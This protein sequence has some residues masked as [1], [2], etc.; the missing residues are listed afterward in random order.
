MSLVYTDVDRLNAAKYAQPFLKLDWLKTLFKKQPYIFSWLDVSVEIKQPDNTMYIPPGLKFYDVTIKPSKIFCEKFSCMPTLFDRPC[1][2]FDETQILRIGDANDFMYACQPSCFDTVFQSKTDN[3]KTT[4]LTLDWDETTQ[5][6]NLLE[7]RSLAYMLA[8]YTRNLKRVTRL[9]DLPV[10]FTKVKDDSIGLATPYFFKTNKTYCD[11]FYIGYDGYECKDPDDIPHRLTDLFIGSEVIRT[12]KNYYRI[13]S[14]LVQDHTFKEYVD[15]PAFNPPEI[16]DYLTRIG[17]HMHINPHFTIPQIETS[18]SNIVKRDVTFTSF[19]TT[20]VSENIVSF[21]AKL[22]DGLLKSFS[23]LNSLQDMGI[24]LAGDSALGAIKSMLKKIT[25][26]LFK[27]MLTSL[28]KVSESTVLSKAVA[29]ALMVNSVRQV[30]EMSIVKVGIELIIEGA[31]S[32]VS[33][34]GF[35]TLVST[36]MDILLRYMDIFSFNSMINTPH[37]K[38]IWTTSQSS[39]FK[40][41]NG[42]VELDWNRIICF[43]FTHEQLL[44]F[45]TTPEHYLNSLKYLDA[46]TVNSDGRPIDRSEGINT[47][48]FKRLIKDETLTTL[49]NKHIDA[50]NIEQFNAYNKTHEQRLQWFTE[51]GA[52]N[53][54]WVT[55]LLVGC[56]F[57]VFKFY[58]LALLA[59]MIAFFCISLNWLNVKT[60]NVG[61]LWANYQLDKFFKS[62][63]PI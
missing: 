41:A 15:P 38:T 63:N 10:N 30:F 28:I 61:K 4:A 62:L 9:T 52:Q 6:C 57:L 1:T 47:D 46:L 11:N 31:T 16:P 48:T 2:K 21:M 22:I 56:L 8:P 7:F 58:T 19:S 50:L 32:V 23:D 5:K 14:N 3:D 18:Y 27:Q 34:V 60:F 17:W 36:F 12:V 44:S 39:M 59:I 25:P 49:V 29:E 45:Y 51:K 13:A 54:F 55:P 42:N 20:G 33:L 26:D 53:K 24:Y 35:I 37:L 40:A 43:Y